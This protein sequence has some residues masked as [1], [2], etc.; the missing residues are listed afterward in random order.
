V[1]GVRGKVAHC[2]NGRTS[3]RDR[4]AGQ[5]QSADAREYEGCEAAKR[6]RLVAVAQEVRVASRSRGDADVAVRRRRAANE[7]VADLRARRSA[8]L[9]RH[10]AL[11]GH[12]SSRAV[13][14]DD[15]FATKVGELRSIAVD[16]GAGSR[17]RVRAASLSDEFRQPCVLV[18]SQGQDER[19]VRCGDAGEQHGRERREIR[20][21]EPSFESA[22]LG[23]AAR[24]AGSASR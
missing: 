19:G 9:R 13:V 1:G 23:E 14:P 12:R 4:T 5:E 7:L 15:A 20:E 2:P 22:Q 11:G 10:D 24:H 6:E 18:G 3:V 21:R 8:A 17:H 16:V